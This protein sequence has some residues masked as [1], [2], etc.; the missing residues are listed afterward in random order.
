MN[1]ATFSALNKALK[2]NITPSRFTEQKGYRLTRHG[3]ENEFGLSD[4]A[5]V[6]SV[7][8]TMDAWWATLSQSEK[9]AGVFG[10]DETGANIKYEDIQARNERWRITSCI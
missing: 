9:D 2:K 10:Q 5:I 8:P 7:L 6:F 3:I 4:T 1:L